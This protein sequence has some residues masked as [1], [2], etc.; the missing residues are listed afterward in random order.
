M[1]VREVN[2]IMKVTEGGPAGVG[3]RLLITLP[4]EVLS[5]G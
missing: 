3:G 2:T 4:K 1:T 5:G